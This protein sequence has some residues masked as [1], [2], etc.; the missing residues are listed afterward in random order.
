M[1]QLGDWDK[2]DDCMHNRP[3]GNIILKFTLGSEAW[4]NKTKEIILRL[5]DKHFFCF[6]PPEPS[7]NFNIAKMIYWMARMTVRNGITGM[8]RMT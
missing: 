1:D 8:T 4:G 3:I 7:M 5:S 2:W 6:I